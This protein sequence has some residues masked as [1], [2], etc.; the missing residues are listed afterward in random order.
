MEVS[1]EILFRI[2]VVWE[3]VYFFQL[4]ELF[5]VEKVHSLIFGSTY[6]LNLS[7]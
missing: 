6:Y 1:I 2:D 3:E 5:I 7:W 4:I